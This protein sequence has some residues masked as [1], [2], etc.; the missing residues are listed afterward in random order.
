[1]NMNP[2]ELSI[3][4][5]IFLKLV[6][7]ELEKRNLW[8]E[9]EDKM[10]AARKSMELFFAEDYSGEDGAVCEVLACMEERCKKKEFKL[11][12]IFQNGKLSID[13]LDG[14]DVEEFDIDTVY[15]L[16]GRVHEAVSTVLKTEA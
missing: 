8:M 15:D 3:Q 12:V 1:M 14:S 9:S 13:Y 6:E 7:A 5:D 2:L 16:Y 11:S 10:E 4:N